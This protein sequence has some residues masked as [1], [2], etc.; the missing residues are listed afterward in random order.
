MRALCTRPCAGALV[1]VLLPCAG[2]LRVHTLCRC[3]YPNPGRVQ[4]L[5]D[6]ETNTIVSNESL[7]IWRILDS[8]FQVTLRARVGIG[9]GFGFSGLGSRVRVRLGCDSSIQ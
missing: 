6:K 9:V 1:Q 8:S 3:S 5:F 7:D 4:V 2:A